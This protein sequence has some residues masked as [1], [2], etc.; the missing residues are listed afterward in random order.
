MTKDQWTM[1]NGKEMEK[2]RSGIGHCPIGHVFF[3]Q[4]LSRT[5]SVPITGRRESVQH[6]QPAGVNGFELEA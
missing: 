5:I 2:S 4:K 3:N 1:D 6:S